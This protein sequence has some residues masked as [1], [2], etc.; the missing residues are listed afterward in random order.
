MTRPAIWCAVSWAA[1]VFGA[2]ISLTTGNWTAG[3]YAFA[4][5]VSAAGWLTADRMRE[6]WQELAVTWE[7]VAER[8]ARPDN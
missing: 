1:A 4:N 7:A 2:A 8:L 5:A 6:R 3:V